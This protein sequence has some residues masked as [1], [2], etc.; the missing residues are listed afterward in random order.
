MAPKRPL[1]SDESA[2][3]GAKKPR[4]EG[5]GDGDVEM[6]DGLSA[7]I[8]QYEID[9]EPF[10]DGA[11]AK[12]VD[13]TL[14]PQIRLDDLD[15]DHGGFPDDLV[16]DDNGTV[17]SGYYNPISPSYK[18]PK[19]PVTTSRA[20]TSE[21]SFPASMIL[22]VR[23]A[24]L[25]FPK[26]LIPQIMK[27]TPEK[28][29]IFELFE[30]VKRLDGGWIGVEGKLGKGGQGCARLFV[31]V[32]DQKRITK[33]VVI[34][35]SWQPIELWAQEDW[36]EKG[37]LG[38]DPRES[39]MNRLLSL[40]TPERWERYIVEY[41]GH[42][43]NHIWKVSRTY[44]EYCDG[45]DLHNLMN[46]Q[47]KAYR[48]LNP[49]YGSE[50]SGHD[51][52][53]WVDSAAGTRAPEP[54]IWYYLKQM[55]VALH[56][57]NN[58]PLRRYKDNYQVV[59]QDIKPQNIFLTHPDPEDFP[60][61]PICKVSTPIIHKIPQQ[62]SDHAA[63][64]GD[65]GS[66][67]VTFPLDPDNPGEYYDAVTP[68]YIAPEMDEDVC[69]KE[70]W[71]LSSAT[72]IA[73]SAVT[74]MRLENPDS[75]NYEEKGWQEPFT[76]DL[77][78][79]TFDYSIELRDLLEA[80]LSNN[81]AS[82]PRPRDIIEWLY[83]KD[84]QPH[85]RQMATA[86]DCNDF[87]LCSSSDDDDDDEDDNDNATVKA[88]AKKLLDVVGSAVMAGTDDDDEEEEEEEEEED[89]DEDD[90]GGEEEEEV[91]EEA[92]GTE[93]LDPD[94][95]DPMA[96]SSGPSLSSGSPYKPPRKR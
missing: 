44:M 84:V 87:E 68:G 66:S 49:N 86:P 35:D 33:R 90:E 8:D 17:H 28:H 67:H 11:K 81:P 82:R 52:P 71:E 91:E 63:K 94:F 85:W 53:K 26:V 79:L 51:S 69:N 20:S 92:D 37:R 58:I 78:D 3:V 45:G 14:V 23:D 16:Y 89:D 32:D 50:G 6:S 30:N 77:A 10:L 12:V 7:F 4:L 65:F 88:K 5:D 56:R 38:Y 41:L 46:A 21:I 96:G 36:W 54:F 76:H 70:A 80:M 43:I 15:Y 62:I 72:N 57:M 25:K 55:A 1:D 34:K 40:P 48:H 61:Y 95:N 13:E 2:K 59:H 31:K 60:Q 24:V 64:I 39:I 9:D 73:M 27:S 47:I 93:D 83:S 42:S 18:M 22:R 75:I 19:S 29:E 74:L